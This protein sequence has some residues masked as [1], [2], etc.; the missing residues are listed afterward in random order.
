V[1]SE[2]PRLL[3]LPVLLL[4]AAGNLVEAIHAGVEARGFT[5]MRP[6]HGYAFVRLAPDGATIAEIGEHLGV[7]KQAASQLVDDLVKR[8]YVQVQPHPRDGR[9]KLVTLT[10]R[11]WACTRAADEA[12]YAAVSQWA[13]EL[14]AERVGEMAADLGRVVRPGR[15]RPMW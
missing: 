15:I 3:A 5:D 12:A 8:G 9:A 14:G 11:G 2:D 1:T 4:A 10:E 13:A 7:T 6:A